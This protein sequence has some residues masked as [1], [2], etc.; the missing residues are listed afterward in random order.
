M[1]ADVHWDVRWSLCGLCFVSL[2]D[3]LVIF[4]SRPLT[5]VFLDQI[6][7][8]QQD[9]EMRANTIFSLAGIMRRSDK[10]LILWDPTWTESLWCLVELAAFLKSRQNPEDQLIIRPIFLGPAYM[11]VFLTSLVAFLIVLPAQSESTETRTILLPPFS[12]LAPSLAFLLCA[13]LAAYAGVSALRSYFRSVE[14]MQQRLLSI[15]FD[16]TRCYSCDQNHVSPSGKPMLSDRKVFVHCMSHWFGGQDAFED[17][18]HTEVRKTMVNGL[19]ESVA[20]TQW[21]LDATRPLMVGFFT[22]GMTEIVI[23]LKDDSEESLKY[24]DDGL[25]HVL[26]SFAT[27]LLLPQFWHLVT[28]VCKHTQ[29]RPESHCLEFAKNVTSIVALG[30]PVSG[31]MACVVWINDYQGFSSKTEAWHR[32]FKQAKSLKPILTERSL[33]FLG[34][35][36]VFAIFSKFARFLIHRIAGEPE[37]TVEEV[38]ESFRSSG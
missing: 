28:F 35:L 34:C 29:A 38:S 11:T 36:L 15:S 19:R 37:V 23:S 22:L 12:G 7:I 14:S 20:I 27:L 6:C 26:V 4:F 16:E 2:A 9:T 24:S 21:I 5:P 10:M 25:S 3:W 13:L 32:H 33:V 30:I 8:K 17:I 1:A 31:V 18:L